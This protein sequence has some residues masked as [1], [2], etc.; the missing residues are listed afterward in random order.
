[1]SPIT[2]DKDR[3]SRLREFHDCDQEYKETGNRDA[4]LRRDLAMRKHRTS[5]FQYA[6]EQISGQL[7]DEHSENLRF[8]RKFGL[9]KGWEQRKD[10]EGL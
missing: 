3:K 9:D 5:D 10:A 1:M 7:V 8:Q 6:R 4:A 2:K